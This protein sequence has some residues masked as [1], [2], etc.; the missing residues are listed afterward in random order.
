[1]PVSTTATAMQLRYCVSNI[2]FTSTY[3]D[4]MVYFMMTCKL[5]LLKSNEMSAAEMMYSCELASLWFPQQNP[6][7]YLHIFAENQ[8]CNQLK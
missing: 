8:L 6:M 3:G 2:I 7:G 4:G 5:T 1:M